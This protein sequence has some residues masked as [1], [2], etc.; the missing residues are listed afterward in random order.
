MLSTKNLYSEYVYG[1]LK[2]TNTKHM[3]VSRI[4]FRLLF[5]LFAFIFHL[6]IPLHSGQ[7]FL[8]VL[9]SIPALFFYY[10][11]NSEKKLSITT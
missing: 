5:P 6:P 10:C 3:K 7:H 1:K 2:L 11:Y 8:L 4:M 9:S